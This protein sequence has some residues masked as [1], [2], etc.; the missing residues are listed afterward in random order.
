M[1][2]SP[3]LAAT[4]PAWA[5]CSPPVVTTDRTA[6]FLSAERHSAGPLDG[7]RA[8]GGPQMTHDPSVGGFAHRPVMLTEVLA[9][10]EP[11]PRGLLVDATLGGAG[12][13]AAALEAFPGLELVGIDRDGDAVAAARARLAGFGDRARAYHARFDTLP[14]VV[15]ADR[16]RPGAPADPPG[17]VAVLF[18]LGVSSHQ[19]DLPQRGF[20]YRAEG[21]LDMRMDATAG[22]TAA[23][24]LDGLD[25]RGLARLLKAHG[26]ARFAAR[27]ARAVLAARPLRTTAE[28]AAAVDAAVPAAARRRGHPAR[29]VFQALRVAVNDELDILPSAIDAAIDLLVPGGRCVVLAY[30]SGEDRIVKDR[31]L[32]AATG[33]CTCP[34]G[35]PCVCGAEPVVRLLNRGA[36]KPGPAEVAA[37]PRARSA[38][39]RVAERLDVA[40][41]GDR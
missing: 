36:R 23:E 37:S 15:A 26:E 33:G 6:P 1:T 9:L 30:H 5:L 13:A 25:E 32:A 39:L 7:G 11:L 18:D 8:T 35:L 17:V 21:P 3:T 29:R 19:L 16:A 24:L 14:A 12:H 27:I 28:L 34:P 22:P 2:P 20:S 10:L 40:P 31:F 41:G 4:R 38:R